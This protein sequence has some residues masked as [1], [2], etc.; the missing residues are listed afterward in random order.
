MK[1]ILTIYLTLFTEI[2]FAQQN[3]STNNALSSFIMFGLLFVL[4]YF[5]LIRPQSK[6]AKEHKSLIDNLKIN[7]EI[8]TNGGI[9][10]KISKITDDFVIM[11]ITDEVKITIKKEAISN[12]IPKGTMKNINQ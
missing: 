11:L 3:D 7:D 5:L 2:L 8:I 1:L 12:A 4:M 10:G 9:V 6:K